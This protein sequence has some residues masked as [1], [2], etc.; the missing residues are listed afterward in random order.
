MNKIKGKLGEKIALEYLTTRGLDLIE[1]N[2]TIWG[3]EIDIIMLDQS[4][5][6]VF[7]EVK[8]RKSH[9]VATMELLSSAKI[10]K[11]IQTS[12]Y[13]IHKHKLWEENWRIDIVLVTENATGDYQ[14]EWIQNAISG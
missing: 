13:W 12:T 8:F 2:F 11:L 9:Y 3:G 4:N 7:V 10:R 6:Y 5:E 1:R 14:I